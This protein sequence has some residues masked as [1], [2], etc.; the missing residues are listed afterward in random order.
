M[1][2]NEWFQRLD[3]AEKVLAVENT[4]VSVVVVRIVV[5]VKVR[6]EGVLI[7]VCMKE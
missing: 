7:I 5:V 6:I 4:N 2:A 1:A 3:G